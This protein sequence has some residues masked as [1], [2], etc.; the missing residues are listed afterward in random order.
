MTMAEEY[1]FFSISLSLISSVI[2]EIHIQTNQQTHGKDSHLNT[3]AVVVRYIMT[4]QLP[5]SV[6]SK[7]IAFAIVFTS[8][9][10]LIMIYDKTKM[11]YNRICTNMTYDIMNFVEP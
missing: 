1:G 10:H 4:S 7:V 3:N 6:I 9:I 2:I 11:F 8:T 5:L